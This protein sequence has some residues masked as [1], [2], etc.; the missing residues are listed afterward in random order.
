MAPSSANGAQPRDPDP[1]PGAQ[2][3]ASGG[4]SG[5]AGT[6]AASARAN[7]A[8]AT[9]APAESDAANDVGSDAAIGTAELLELLGADRLWLLQQIDAGHWPE[10][11]L[12]LAA[13]EREL[14]QL[15][16]QAAERLPSP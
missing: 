11:R 13:L 15:L 10:L 6:D 5:P 4:A 2:L 12:D 14:G 1:Q 16:D 9:P 8:G 3:G 7:G